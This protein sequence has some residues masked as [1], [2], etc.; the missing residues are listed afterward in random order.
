MSLLSSLLAATG[1]YV[2][3]MI[4][5]LLAK[6]GVIEPWVGAWSP[7]IIFMAAGIILFR[8]ART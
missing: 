8:L 6:T 5:M 4:T 7:L 3:Q 2:A 1:Y